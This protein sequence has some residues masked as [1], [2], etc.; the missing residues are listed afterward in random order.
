M[1]LKNIKNIINN[2]TILLLLTLLTSCV[3]QKNKEYPE[4]KDATY[5][6]YDINGERGYIVEFELSN[7]QI[8]PKAVVINRIKKT[9]TPADKDG[10]KYRINV[11]A[12]TR[13]IVNYRIEGSDKENGIFFSTEADDNFK[14][15][16]F[17]LK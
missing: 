4:V 17:N 11:I 16:D 7:D 12:Q 9:I 8:K 14:P 13:K 6:S 3:C 10:L 1:K 5:K 15:V 2:F